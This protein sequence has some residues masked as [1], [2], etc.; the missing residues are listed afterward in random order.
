MFYIADYFSPLHVLTG[1]DEGDP[2]AVQS[3]AERLS[4]KAAQY[5]GVARKYASDPARYA[6]VIAMAE[7]WAEYTE[8][9]INTNDAIRRYLTA[10]NAST[11][12]GRAERQRQKAAAQELPDARTHAP[13]TVPADRGYTAAQ[14]DLLRAIPQRYL[15]SACLLFDGDLT[16]N[17]YFTQ[18]TV[19]AYQADAKRFLALNTK[20]LEAE[21]IR[22]V[23]LKNEGKASEKDADLVILAAEMLQTRYRGEGFSFTVTH[24][25]IA[26]DG[27]KLL[28]H[29]MFYENYDRYFR[30]GDTQ[31][32]NTLAEGA[33]EDEYAETAP[34]QDFAALCRL[35]GGYNEYVSAYSAA[36]SLGDDNL[37]ILEACTGQGNGKGVKF[38]RVVYES[39]SG[40]DR[41]E[42][43]QYVFPS[44][45]T[46]AAGY[47]RAQEL[48]AQKDRLDFLASLG[49]APEALTDMTA[50][51]SFR[52]DQFL[53]AADRKIESVKELQVFMSGG[54]SA[55][56]TCY[57]LRLYEVDAIAGL[58]Y[59]GYYSSDPYI[60]FDGSLV[61]QLLFGDEEETGMMTSPNHE[62]T[63]DSS[64][65]L[66]RFG[67]NGIPGYS[68]AAYE[69]GTV[70]H[71]LETGGDN[72][73]F[74]VDFADQYGAGLECLATAW[75]GDKTLAGGGL[76]EALAL[77]VRYRDTYGAVRQTVLP[78]I[79]S[80][81]G[82]A[83]IEGEVGGGTEH[84]GLAQ[85]GESIAFS[86]VL[87]E[88]KSLVNVTPYFGGAL[89]CA[90]AKLT[91]T[92]DGAN[93]KGRDAAAAASETD[94][95]GITC[96]AVYSPRGGALRAL[97]DGGFIRYSFPAVPEYVYRVREATGTRYYPGAVNSEL[98]LAAVG[99][100]VT[101][102]N[103]KPQL[104]KEQYLVTLVTDD[105]DMGGTTSDVTVRLGYQD[106][107][108]IETETGAI[109]IREYVSDFYGYWPASAEDFGYRY[110]LSVLRQGDGS[111]K[112]NS[113]SF[114]LPVRDV[115][116]FTAVSLGVSGDD[117]WQVKNVLIHTVESVG[118]RSVQWSPGLSVS[119][120]RSDR[121][122][123]REI[124][125]K[126]V[127]DLAANGT[128]PSDGTLLPDGTEPSDG[129]PAQGGTNPAGGGNISG[130]G[131]PGFRPILIQQGDTVKLDVES[132]E[133]YERKEVNWSELR[134]NMTY[135]DAM[136][137]LGFMKA[138]NTYT[139]EVLVGSDLNNV[140]GD[141]DCGSKNQFYFQLLFADGNASGIV[142]AN[143][144]LE[145]D[146][147]HSGVTE[148]FTLTTSQDYGDVEA[149]RVI[150]EDTASDSDKYDKLMIERLTVKRNT[151]GELTPLWRVNDVGWI[152]I[153][154]RD[155]GTA[156]SLSGVQG[157]TMEELS[158]VFPVSES[159]YA[160][161]VQFGISTG[162]YVDRSA[163][164]N[165]AATPQFEGELEAWIY[166]RDTQGRIQ[167]YHVADV[168]ER[169]YAF[170][171]R[172]ASYS[173]VEANGVSTNGKAVSDPDYM[174]RAGHTDRFEVSL[175]GLQRLLYINFFAKS[176]VNCTWNVNDVEA[177]LVHGQGRRVL[178]V[179]GEYAMV[180]PAGQ[181][182]E[183]I[184]RADSQ[185][186]PK[187]YKQLYMG[188]AAGKSTPTMTVNFADASTVKI[189]D[190]VL[191]SQTI[192]R[193]VPAT[194]SDTLNVVL[195]PGRST[196]SL[197]GYDLTATARYTR[198]GAIL[199]SS[200]RMNK[201]EADGETM[202]YVEGLSVNG[203][204]VLNNLAVIASTSASTETTGGYLQRVRGGFV[205]ETY[206]LGAMSNL[207]FGMS[208]PL[209][210]A[211]S[212]Q[213]KL[214]FQ[215]AP[216]TTPMRL[217]AEKTD[218]AVSF[219]YRSDG[220]IEREYESPRIFLTDQGVTSVEPGQIVE[221][222]FA[223][224]HVKEITGVSVFTVG[225]VNAPIQG[226][227]VVAQ[228]STDEGAAQK[229]RYSFTAENGVSSSGMTRLSVTPEGEADVR[230][231][232][233]RFETGT[234]T[235]NQGGGAN[236]SVAVRVCYYNSYGD[237]NTLDIE[238]IRPFL[239]GGNKML[240]A[241]S[242]RE[243]RVFV[244]G[245][246][247]LRWIELAAKAE[248]AGA[249]VWNLKKVG[250]QLGED[251]HLYERAVT[252]PLISDRDYRFSLADIVLSGEV[253]LI[254]IAPDPAKTDGGETDGETED[255]EADGGEAEDKDGS[256]F[257]LTLGAEPAELRIR[258][259]DSVVLRPE[260][261]GSREGWRADVYTLYVGTG[262]T[263]PLSLADTRGYT[264]ESLAQKAA[265]AE[266]ALQ[267]ETERGAELKAES[268]RTAHAAML[269]VLQAEL[270]YWSTFR[271]EAGKL[272][273]E[274]DKVT[275]TPP[276]NYT[277][278]AVGY[279]IV[280]TAKEAENVRLTLDIVVESEEDPVT[281]QLAA[282]EQTKQQIR[283]QQAID[284]QREVVKQLEEKTE[285]LQRQVEDMESKMNDIPDNP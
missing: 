156:N 133:V 72:A 79:T 258:S 282:F 31:W 199:D 237:E 173:E 12:E 246:A 76:C 46:L 181:E 238:D 127:F 78:M 254:E 51:E 206:E 245:F 265:D 9:L 61:A 147:F 207:E 49:Y 92:A 28:R 169:M 55:S 134:F 99:T 214:T 171:N 16:E 24:V 236:G 141:D 257:R 22:L 231:L 11:A 188:V 208:I 50:L 182:L 272:E 93:T 255:G 136:Q 128:L 126:P 108:G 210:S 176:T 284:A 20:E 243:A 276:R 153:D 116:R 241:G 35:F 65:V 212:E 277:L 1:L 64:G 267:A 269:R 53:F 216:E 139:V 266:A 264:E 34:Y 80:A 161:N 278:G 95:V 273:V 60:D 19:A 37:Y 56:W 18:Y 192:L 215:L 213:Q 17:A 5:R 57:A 67:G 148:S 283:E 209:V 97:L 197:A 263:G 256:E 15:A 27:T 98:T 194:G 38:I 83:A 242:T 193:R 170:N 157:R 204:S 119:G 63:L 195:Y 164:G 120:G 203:M 29:S 205:L 137:D 230:P 149:V 70:R 239:S 69:A 124:A 47:R 39:G 101:V 200:S 54:G 271:P 174:F 220:P 274:S 227:Y 228:Y 217:S 62:L 244:S 2:A 158:H 103:L 82:W 94:E 40:N 152:G 251:G 10:Q 104:E 96:I 229:G 163:A 144:Q 125:G 58:K 102:M 112:G 177:W 232:I 77:R 249:T 159:S 248:G 150:P 7:A 3:E 211:S 262:A 184:G 30:T 185:M 73:I 81:A 154:Y 14:L 259:G 234:G 115:E 100:D 162:N 23:A 21:Y 13:T 59:S 167:R 218:I 151:N 114:L 138:R 168:V 247:E 131:T 106:V 88:Y 36:Q 84:A 186:V 223:Q 89:A 110:G 191:E 179:A 86:C 109:D 33:R 281:Q 175:D 87:P 25:D 180:Y 135:S 178:N 142:L 253:T 166:Y 165:G 107:D 121:V 221:L 43:T 270:T 44:E 280:I 143:Q 145:S 74:R 201:S 279:R 219:T 48:G 235:D 130:G 105:V 225:S 111:A 132:A 91:A 117:E 129:T 198:S 160:V 122:I 118:P 6:A 113:V 155:E 202:F 42:C 233:L 285:A 26:A 275:F 189:D 32:L 250:A 75:D 41:T 85:Q 68:L 260:L 226:G 4:D 268:D 187:Y 252:E 140:S 261:I 222:V 71:Y 123:G 224:G 240:S 196:A 190:T 172:A 146:G 90:Q 8:T 183:S 45:N 52:T 66:F